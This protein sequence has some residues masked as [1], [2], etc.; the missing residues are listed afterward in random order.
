VLLKVLVGLPCHHKTLLR[1]LQRTGD[2]ILIADQQGAIG[3]RRT[4]PIFVP[5]LLAC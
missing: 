3:I 1:G 5:L 4:A 2:C